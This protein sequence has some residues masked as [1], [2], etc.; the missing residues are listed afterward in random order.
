MGSGVARAVLA[1]PSFELVGVFARRPERA[2][3]DVGEALGLAA[4]VGVEIRPDLA[5][6]AAASRAHVAIQTTCSRLRD[7]VPELEPLLAAGISCVSIAEELAW[8]AAASRAL[9]ARLDELARRG[10]AAVLG[11]GVNPG[12][13]LDLL[14]VVLSGA[15]AAVDRI[16][17]TRVNDLSPYGP[18]VL[19]SQGVG[20]TPAAFRAG[21]ASGAVVGHFGFPQSIGMIARALGWEVERLEERREPIVSSVARETPFARVEPGQVAGCHHSAVAHVD[22]RPAIV[23]DHPQQIRPELAGVVT[24]D[25]I[26]VHGAPG[27]RLTGSPEIPGGAATVALAVNAVPRVLAAAPGLL[28]MLDLPPLAA[29]PR[30]RLAPAPARAGREGRP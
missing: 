13:V 7:A 16:E 14:P 19:A 17:A 3:L 6:L 27:L 20:L 18:T 9:A 26:E 2:G 28:S 15:C 29:L 30:G 23:L 1:T 24:G 11:T 25:T 8:P 10:G 5:A 4:P 21:V 22:G 12:F